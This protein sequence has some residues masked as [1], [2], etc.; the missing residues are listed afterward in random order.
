MEETEGTITV[1]GE[2]VVVTDPDEVRFRLSLSA[3]RSRHTE[4][5]P[6]VTARSHELDALFD[7]L[8]IPKTKRSTSG[9]S[10]R[11]NREWVEER[12]VHRGYEALSSIIVR[13]HDPTIAAGSWK[14]PSSVHRHSSTGRGGPW[15]ETTQP[16]SRPAGRRRATLGGKRRRTRTHRVSRWVRSCRS[17]RPSRHRGPAA[18]CCRTGH[19]QPPRRRSASNR[20]SST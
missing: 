13:L 7:E 6:D 20:D 17:G 12:S 1:R 9:I 18:G 4:A 10:I 8:G 15:T 3:V 14:E 5:L 11:E 16:G 19:E 2:A